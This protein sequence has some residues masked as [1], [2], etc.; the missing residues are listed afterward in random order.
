MIEILDTVEVQSKSVIVPNKIGGN[1]Q[2]FTKTRRYSKSEYDRARSDVIWKL[3]S[4][5]LDLETQRGD[6]ENMVWDI[7]SYH[8]KESFGDLDIVINS[9]YLK[10]N[11]I[12]II[13]D[14]FN[15][16]VGD[17]S[18]NGNVF[19]FV[20]QELQ[21]DLIVT[22]DDD[23]H[24]S[25]D[26]FKFNDLSN[27]EGRIFHKL[28]LKHGHKGTHVIIKD[29]DYEI[30]E[31]LVTKSKKDAHEM[32]GLNHDE[33]EIGFDTMEDAY[34]WVVKSPFFNSE[35]YQYA[36][37]NHYSRTRDKKRVNYHNFLL[38]IETQHNL[39]NYPFEDVTEKDGHNSREPFFTDII[40]KKFPHVKE[41]YDNL[42]AKHNEDKLFKEKFN[43]EFV[44]ELT[45]L[46]GKE[47]GMFMQYCRT[48]IEETNTRRLFLM[49]GKHTCGLIISSMY[50]YYKMGFKFLQFPY[51]LAVKIARNEGLVK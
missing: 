3:Y 34:K 45:G 10:S 39:P 2:F 48:S 27:I 11:Y 51:D 29:G 32:I 47:L 42:I 50:T 49:H 28:G 23:F 25:L 18:K 26:Y 4:H 31:I 8:S 19:S 13:V 41:Q 7:E 37:R 12:D 21:V 17:W 24:T 36:N 16:R 22:P 40:C 43:G 5:V 20:Y 14:K 44:M 30:G 38:W 9:K 1:I 15:L 35:I 6:I 33:W 46:S